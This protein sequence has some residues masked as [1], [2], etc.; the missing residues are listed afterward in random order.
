ML[1]FLDVDECASG[2]GMLCRNGQCVNTIGSFQCL[3]ND[4]YEVALDG[5]TCVDINECALEP[6][7][8]SPGTCQNLDGSFRCICPP[9][10]ILQD[11]KCEGV[12]RAILL[13]SFS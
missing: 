6:G 7:K 2:N 8:C 12:Y 5:R 11:D 1:F 9:G 10:Y 3:C 13:L 4:G